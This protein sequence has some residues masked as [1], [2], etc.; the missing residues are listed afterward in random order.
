MGLGWNLSSYV[1]TEIDV[2]THSFKFSVLSDGDANARSIGGTLY[3]DFA[4]RYVR[5]GDVTKRRTFV[6]FMGLGAG[7]G[8]YRFE[9]ADGS[10]GMYIAPR[11]ILGMNFALT[12][13]IGI[14]VAYQY[15]MFIGNG[16]GWD[17]HKGGVQS[18]S[19]IMVS[20]RYNF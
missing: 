19:D 15:Q 17:V 10:D 1:R 20:F 5:M 7:I 2:Q 9:G 18:L 3:F 6:P 14:D 4:R 16:F 8:S 11:G 12:D 13:L